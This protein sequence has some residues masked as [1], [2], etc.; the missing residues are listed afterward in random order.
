M[1]EKRYPSHEVHL[2]SDF[3]PTVIGVNINEL[4]L[5]KN[6]VSSITPII[7]VLDEIDEIYK[8]VYQEK[9]NHDPRILH[10]RSRTS[11]NR[12]MDIIGSTPNVIF[13]GTTE[14]PLEKL[15]ED[16]RFHSFMRIGRI[17]H[18]VEMSHDFDKTKQLKHK[19]IVGYPKDSPVNMI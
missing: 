18:F 2:F 6:V 15:Y 16:K 13:I 7:I 12:M 9:Q 8:D 3:D 4:I 17:D 14:L 19:D 5:N 10:T 1:Y 11:F